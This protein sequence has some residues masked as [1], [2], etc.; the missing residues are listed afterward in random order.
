M[1]SNITIKFQHKYDAMPP[2]TPPSPAP[3]TNILSYFLQEGGL[4]DKQWF[5]GGSVLPV[6]DKVVLVKEH[7]IE[8]SEFSPNFVQSFRDLLKGHF[9][10]TSCLSFLNNKI[11][12]ILFMKPAMHTKGSKWSKKMTLD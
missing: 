4:R 9:M 1:T 3:I 5:P 10:A 12:F 8:K 7:G 11:V 6:N 2:T